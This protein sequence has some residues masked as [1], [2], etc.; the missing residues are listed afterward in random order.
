MITYIYILI[1][2]HKAKET[3]EHINVTFYKYNEYI[4]KLRRLRNHITKSAAL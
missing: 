3:V 4:A 2:I 1:H